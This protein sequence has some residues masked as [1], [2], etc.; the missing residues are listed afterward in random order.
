M[1]KTLIKLTFVVALAI[2]SFM[3]CRK[4]SAASPT[5]VAASNSSINH[6]ITQGAWKVTEFT[7][8]NTNKTDHYFGY[9]FRF[10]TNSTVD[11]FSLTNSISGTWSTRTD[12]GYLKMDLKFSNSTFFKELN[13]DWQVVSQSATK[14]K[15]LDV[16]GNAGKASYLTFERL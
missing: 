12:S 16:S 8:E 5:V 14:I 1:I 6:N 9:E 4:D 10:N 2:L 15:L 11:A 3:A 13:E 7:E